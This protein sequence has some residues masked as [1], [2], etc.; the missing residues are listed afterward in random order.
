MRKLGVPVALLRVTV[1]RFA[2]GPSIVRFLLINNSP[3][4]RVIGLVTLDISKVIVLPAHAPLM[5]VRKEPGPLSL[6]LVTTVGPHGPVTT[7]GSLLPGRPGSSV[8]RL[9]SFVP[10]PSASYLIVP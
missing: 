6:L 3:V 4:V 1:S 10:L 5:I 7:V 2:P 9:A 8:R